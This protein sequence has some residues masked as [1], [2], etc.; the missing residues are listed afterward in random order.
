MDNFTT[1]TYE[2]TGRVTCTTQNR[3]DRGN[4]ITLVMPRES[5]RAVEL[6]NLAPHVHVMASAA[7]GRDSAAGTT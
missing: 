7:T 2:R 3:P 6:A 4:G 5:A 1:M